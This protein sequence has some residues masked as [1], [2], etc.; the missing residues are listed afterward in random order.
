MQKSS[1]YGGRFMLIRF[2][3]IYLDLVWMAEQPNV[4]LIFLETQLYNEETLWN[5]DLLLCFCFSTESGACKAVHT[6][7][8]LNVEMP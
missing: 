1:D 2:L 4:S 3:W 5:N 7:D 6:R 8:Y